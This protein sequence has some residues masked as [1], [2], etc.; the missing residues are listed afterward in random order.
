MAQRDLRN[1][2][3]SIIAAQQSPRICCRQIV[4]I[5]LKIVNRNGLWPLLQVMHHSI[6]DN[7]EEYRRSSHE[8]RISVMVEQNLT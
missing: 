5:E 6:R 2:E 4:E 1:P 8:D 3:F 7:R